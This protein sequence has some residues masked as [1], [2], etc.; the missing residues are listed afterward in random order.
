VCRHFNGSWFIRWV[1]CYLLPLC[2][3]SIGFFC[4]LVDYDHEICPIEL[5]SG[6]MDRGAHGGHGAMPVSS[7]VHYGASKW[8]CEKGPHI[9]PRAER[10]AGCRKRPRGRV[11]PHRAPC[12]RG[13]TTRH[14]RLP[15]RRSLCASQT[16]GDLWQFLLALTGL[17]Y[18]GN[19]SATHQPLTCSTN[20]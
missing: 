13:C 7:G 16:P 11:S 5:V 20:Q 4:C 12:P 18:S 1:T 17:D 9:T 10:A 15:P 8:P 2:S 6:A 14:P 3:K 19:R